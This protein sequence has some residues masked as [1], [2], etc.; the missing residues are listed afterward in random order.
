L[1]K[2]KKPVK[3]KKAAKKIIKKAKPKP[4]RVGLKPTIQPI[5]K[6]LSDNKGTLRKKM[7]LEMLRYCIVWAYGEKQTIE[8]FKQRGEELSHTHYYE[9]KAEFQ[10][11]ES[12]S[13]WYSEQALSAMESTHKMGVQQLDALIE[14]TMT[15]IQ[16]LQATPVYLQS[17][18]KV[19]GGDDVID[20]KFN[21]SHNSIALAK[22]IETHGNLMKIRD[23]MLAATPVVQAIMN[24][25]A[26]NREKSMTTR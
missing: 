18:R 16:Q 11:D 24:K 20:T 17:L 22:M 9:L 7:K 8:Y 2:K 6:K 25:A 1:I 26:E 15:E 21:P 23:D 14:V 12:T 19:K 10:S 4:I 13:G 5:E 3:K